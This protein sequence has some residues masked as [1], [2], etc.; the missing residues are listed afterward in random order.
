MQL[1]TDKKKPKSLYTFILEFF[2]TEYVT[3]NR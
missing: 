3:I 1:M 2:K